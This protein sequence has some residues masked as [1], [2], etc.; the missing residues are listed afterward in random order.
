MQNIAQGR[1]RVPDHVENIVYR[2]IVVLLQIDFQEKLDDVKIVDASVQLMAH[3]ALDGLQ[4][5]FGAEAL[6]K[7]TGPAVRLLVVFHDK[8]R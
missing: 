5:F 3:E 1:L 2:I 4:V 6:L 8:Q 7:K